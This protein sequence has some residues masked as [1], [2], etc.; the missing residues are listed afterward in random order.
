M[1]TVQEIKAAIEALSPAER[2]ELD[3][4]LRETHPPLDPELDSPELETELLKAAN[5][6]FTPFS[7]EDLRQECEQI[8]RRNRQL[9]LRHEYSSGN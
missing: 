8:A 7:P 1:S 9:I 6:P 2:A 4:L 3:R 5:G